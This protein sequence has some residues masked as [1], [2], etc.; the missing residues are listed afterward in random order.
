M[1]QKYYR[2]FSGHWIPL[3][4]FPQSNNN[5]KNKETDVKMWNWSG[6]RSCCWWSESEETTTGRDGGSVE[7]VLA[8]ALGRTRSERSDDGRK[9]KQTFWFK[10][11]SE[12][13]DDSTDVSHD[14][15]T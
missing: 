6:T 11:P 8:A 13:C 15:S 4:V 12:H 14:T 2:A 10:I 3:C 7:D 5:I 9:H 1:V